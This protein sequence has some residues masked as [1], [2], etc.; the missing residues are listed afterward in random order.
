[1]RIC[2]IYDYRF[3]DT[4]NYSEAIYGSIFMSAEELYGYLC[5][6]F[7]TNIVF[8]AWLP[9]IKEIEILSYVQLRITFHSGEQVLLYDEDFGG[10]LIECIKQYSKKEDK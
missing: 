5:N 7:H 4:N 2:G 10:Y 6:D 8:I 3:N 9:S 1:M